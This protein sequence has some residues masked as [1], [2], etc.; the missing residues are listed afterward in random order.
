[1]P[2]K[3]FAVA[4]DVPGLIESL[5]DIPAVT[6]SSDSQSPKIAFCFT[7]QGA[8]NACMGGD[9][10]KY[11]V[12]RN[13]LENCENTL[14]SLGCRWSLSEELN[15]SAA[16]TNLN[17]AEFSQPACTALQIAL[18]DLL[19]HWGIQP[20]AVVGHSSGEIAAAYCKSHIF[21]AYCYFKLSE[22]L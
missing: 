12:Y 10:V 6:R 9:L 7:G 19:Q 13:S 18:V 2:W 17:L 16:D 8:Q 15:R 11:D 22:L 1:M 4:A 5:G 21:Q 20:S 3:S 14:R